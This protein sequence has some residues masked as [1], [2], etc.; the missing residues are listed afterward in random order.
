M[1]ESKRALALNST[2]REYRN[3]PLRISN[4]P[5]TPRKQF[6]VVEAL[7]PQESL[8]CLLSTHLN[9]DFHIRKNCRKIL[10]TDLKFAADAIK[11]P[12]RIVED[13]TSLHRKM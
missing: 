8:T 2:Y 13:V 12:V 7:D 6:S 11:M 5:F 3:G 10:I 1:E 4:I 9:D